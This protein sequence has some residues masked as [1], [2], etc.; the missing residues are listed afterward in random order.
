VRL[1]IL[2]PVL[3]YDMTEGRIVAWHKSVGDAVRRGEPIADVETDKATMAFESIASGILV[4]IV[5][6]AGDVVSVGAEIAYLD[7]GS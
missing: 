1:P 6:S 5:H 4:E 2:M 7:T 3:G